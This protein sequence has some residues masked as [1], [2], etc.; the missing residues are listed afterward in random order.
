VGAL[1]GQP[2]SFVV[3]MS[4]DVAAAASA[5]HAA[6]ALFVPPGAPTPPAIGATTTGWEAAAA[7][8]AASASRR[9]VGVAAAAALEARRAADVQ[10]VLSAV[11]LPPGVVASPFEGHTTAVPELADLA[12]AMTTRPPHL[13]MLAHRRFDLSA[14]ANRL[15]DLLPSSGKAAAIAV[16]GAGADS[17]NSDGSD[18]SGSILVA[19]A[20]APATPAPMVALGAAPQERVGVVG[21]SLSRPPPPPGSAPA[22]AAPPPLSVPAFAEL[23]RGVFGNGRATGW[24]FSSAVSEALFVP[25]GLPSSAPDPP[26]EALAAALAPRPAADAGAGA[27]GARLPLFELDDVALLP[28]G[29]EELIIYEPRYRR[30][31]TPR[32]GGGNGRVCAAA[33]ACAHACACNP[34]RCFSLTHAACRAQLDAARCARGIHARGGLSGPRSARVAVWGCVAWRG[35]RRG[36]GRAHASPRRARARGGAR[37]PPLPRAPRQRARAHGHIRAERGRGGLVR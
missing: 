15:D 16:T 22:P 10:L 25:V 24:Y 26:P 11:R 30:A 36:A 8:P 3:H 27:G 33:H 19:A 17:A 4:P 37:R 14:L 28:G 20:A 32:R 34:S 13:L 2:P 12:G 1:G 23:C 31:P 18:G 21:I 35:H 9:S 6:A 5:L 29:R 7:A